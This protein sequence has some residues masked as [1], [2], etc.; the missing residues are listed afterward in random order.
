VNHKETI[1]QKPGQQVK[2]L[3][4]Q[5]AVTVIANLW[6][7]GQIKLLIKNLKLRKGVN[8]HKT[9]SISHESKYY[10]FKNRVSRRKEKVIHPKRS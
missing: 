6:N 3:V 5:R 8:Y 2:I 1:V 9:S 10:C 4:I 7:C